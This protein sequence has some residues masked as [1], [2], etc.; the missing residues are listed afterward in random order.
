MTDQR[1]GRL[2]A[3][4]RT[5]AKG[6]ARWRF[7]CD[8]GT[9]KEIDGYHV[10]CGR[11]VSCGCYNTEVINLPEHK[12]RLAAIA[13]TATLTHGKSKDPV[14]HVWKTMR[15]RCF[16]PLA[17]DYK[18]YG[19]R[20]ISIDPRWDDYLNFEADMGPRPKGLTLERIDNSK[21]Y[22]PEN[23]RW[24][25]WVEQSSNRRSP[26]SGANNPQ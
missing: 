22:G 5:A 18:H 2:V 14:Y 16:N 10:R 19:G 1:Y 4:H 13:G 20:G 11:I 8:C 25:T 26:R 17:K 21:G 3:L 15:Q 24:A 9:L 7:L 6:R 23:C 12:A